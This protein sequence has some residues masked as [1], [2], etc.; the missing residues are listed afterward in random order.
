MDYLQQKNKDWFWTT[1]RAGSRI[2]FGDYYDT[3]RTYRKSAGGPVSA[4]TCQKRRPG[5]EYR[6]TVVVRPIRAGRGTPLC[7]ARVDYLDAL[8]DAADV[9]WVPGSPRRADAWVRSS[10][11]R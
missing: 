2:D 4:T 5:D 10:S 9:E 6:R 1:I 8:T 7:R 11:W 3:S